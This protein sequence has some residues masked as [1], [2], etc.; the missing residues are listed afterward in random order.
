MTIAT[1]DSVTMEYTG[2]LDDG[3]VFDTSR[4]A[5]AEE[6]G[7]AESHPDR[8]FTPVTVEVGAEQ[9][10]TG[11]DAALVGM[12]A[13]EEDTV[14]VPPEKG[15]GELTEDRIEDYDATEFER[16]LDGATPEEGM[17]IQTSQGEFGEVVQAG[18]DVVRVDFNH[19]L[20]G[21]TVEFDI[22]VIEVQ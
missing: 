1:G 9:L 6:S 21:E 18:S 7:L 11:I 13:G 20:A 22:E 3:T 17:H 19:E 14:K 15:Y 10:I 2:R 4:R 5:V 16:M 8:E 12:E